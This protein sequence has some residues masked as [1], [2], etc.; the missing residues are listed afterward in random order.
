MGTKAKLSLLAKYAWFV[1]AFNILVILWGVFL[2]SSKSGDGC[3]RYWLTCNGEVLPSAPQLKTIIEFSHRM[4]T[5]ADGV[6]MIIL[7]GWAFWAWHR[8]RGIQTK[9]TLIASAISIFFV[10]TEAAVGAGLVLTGNTAET[11][12][13]ERPFWMAGHLINTFILSKRG[14]KI[15]SQRFERDDDNE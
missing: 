4:M 6:L 13:D 5:T 7:F 9:S 1:V 14:H 11:L 10:A 12:T 15:C 3:G 8:N 2:R